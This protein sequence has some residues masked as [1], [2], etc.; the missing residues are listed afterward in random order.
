[1]NKTI[2]LHRYKKQH[3]LNNKIL[4]ITTNIHRNVSSKDHPLSKNSK[5][6]KQTKPSS[7]FPTTLTHSKASETIIKL[8]QP[9]YLP[10]PNFPKCSTQ[11]SRNIRST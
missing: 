8:F 6:T 5:F 11:F 4:A 10:F 2:F 9:L 1:M 7:P 3:I